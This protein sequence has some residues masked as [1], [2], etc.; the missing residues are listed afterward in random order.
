MRSSENKYKII[1]ICTVISFLVIWYVLTAKLEIFPLYVLPDP[2]TILM[3]LIKKLTVKT[4][5]GATLITH[6]LTSLQVA[7][8]GFALGLIGVPLGIAMA[9]NKWIE[10]VVRPI[11]NFLRP[12]PP[13][14]W[15]PVMILLFGIG[16]PAKAAVIFMSALIP[17][18]I[19]SYSGIKQ[20]SQVHLWVGRTFG[21]NNFE[22]L[23]KIAIPSALPNIFTGM[24][25][26]LG[27]S[28]VSLV[29]AE[30]LAATKGLGYLIQIGRQFS[31]TD[32]VISGMIVIGIL[33][34]LLAKI[35]EYVEKRFVRGSGR[36]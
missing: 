27:T 4:P 15:I 17:N 24:R 22:L 9:W 10:K 3:T 7:L 21:A 36:T 20:T 19:N 32:L 1:S 6:I 33:G 8:S 29:S 28:L 16:T 5:D 23:I 2:L 26:S 30:M 12:I 34:A 35:L 25:L 13:I 18:V 11:F 31:R 14:T